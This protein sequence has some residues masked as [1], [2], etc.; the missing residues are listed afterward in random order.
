MAGEGHHVLTD[1]DVQALDRRARE[2]GDV[3]GWDLQFV[4]APNGHE[5]V[6]WVTDVAK[7]EVSLSLEHPLAGTTLHFDVTVKDVRAATKEELTH[8]HAHGPD[9]H[10]HH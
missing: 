8:G 3:I 10:H 6:L 4:V 2:V 7:N 1:E 9:G 5:V